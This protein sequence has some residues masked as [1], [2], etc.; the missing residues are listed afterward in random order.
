MTAP[1][2]STTYQAGQSAVV[3]WIDDNNAPTLAQFG[4]ASIAIYVGNAHQQVKIIY[5]YI[6]IKNIEYSTI[7]L[8]KSSSSQC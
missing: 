3:S 5:I 8:D 7:L 6:Y 1:V 4:L 2:A